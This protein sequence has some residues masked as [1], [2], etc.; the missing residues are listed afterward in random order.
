MLGLLQ[1]GLQVIGYSLIFCAPGHTATWHA[2]TQAQTPPRTET[3]VTG[4]VRATVDTHACTQWTFT[5]SKLDPAMTN[6]KSINLLY[7]WSEMLS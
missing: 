5:R 2:I 6:G 7:I 3:L 1:T 4:P